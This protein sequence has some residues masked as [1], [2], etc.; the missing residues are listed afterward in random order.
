MKSHSNLLYFCISEQNGSVMMWN[1]IGLILFFFH[2]V[3][4]P[5]RKK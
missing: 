3:T 4:M 2:I 5:E 1:A